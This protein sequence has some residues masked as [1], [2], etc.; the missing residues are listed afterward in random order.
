MLGLN[1]HCQLLLG[2]TS[3]WQVDD[4]QLLIENN[5]V[6]I[7]ISCVGKEYICSMFGKSV[8]YYGNAPCCSWRHLGTTQF[9]TIITALYLL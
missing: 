3:S 6:E 2:L 1:S 8:C 4:V 5:S 9:E 7:Q